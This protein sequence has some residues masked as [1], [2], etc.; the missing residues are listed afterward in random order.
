M[1]RRRHA[2]G[3]RA[4]RRPRTRP[5]GPDRSVV[6]NLWLFSCSGEG[7][8]QVR[9]IPPRIRNGESFTLTGRLPAEA[10]PH[11][12]GKRVRPQPLRGRMAVFTPNVCFL[13]RRTRIPARVRHRM[14]VEM[15]DF[16]EP[17]QHVFRT[18]K[19]SR[20][21][22]HVRI[23]AQSARHAVAANQRLHVHPLIKLEILMNKL[24]SALVA[25]AIAGTFSLSAVAADA[26]PAAGAAPAAEK[27]AA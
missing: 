20:S 17:I 6:R 27:P 1:P 10:A 15:Q 11:P 25:A 12:A 23:A 4:A 19:S 8:R 24:M 9:R 22:V 26:A 3:R 13:V 7:M 18:E 16:T 14:V 21:K 5:R 2:R